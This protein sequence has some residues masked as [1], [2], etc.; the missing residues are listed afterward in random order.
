MRH[1][2]G[3]TRRRRH[4]AKD[5]AV[6]S[7]IAV[8]F[9]ILLVVAGINAYLITTLPQQMAI[10][11]EQHL[12]QVENA[13]EQLQA[14]ILAEAAHPNKHVTMTT[15]IPMQSGSEPPFGAPASSVLS[16]DPTTSAVANFSYKIGTIIQTPPNWLQGNCGSNDSNAVVSCSCT[17]SGGTKYDNYTADNTTMSLTVHG[18]GSGSCPVVYNIR[19]NNSVITI[20]V[21]GKNVGQ[22]I[23]QIEGNNDT[24]RLVYRGSSNQHRYITIAIYGQNDAYSSDWSG[25]GG[26][27]TAFAGVSVNTTFVG[28]SGLLCP[29]STLSQSD[30]VGAVNP[31]GNTRNVTQ[32]FTWW[33]T[34][35]ALDSAHNWSVGS[36]GDSYGF[37]NVSGFINCAFTVFAG[38]TYGENALSG[39]FDTLGDRYFPVETVGF[40]EGAVIAGTS[41]ESS[42]MIF[43]PELSYNRTSAGNVIRMTLIQLIPTGNLI[44]SGGGTTG[45]ET[46]LLGVS[47]FA[48]TNTPLSLEGKA[49]FLMTPFYLNVTTLYPKAWLNFLQPLDNFLTGTPYAVYSPQNGYDTYEVIIPFFAVGFD[50]T[51]VSVG[52]GF[53]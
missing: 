47:H 26:H 33:N 3:R 40:E 16:A 15:P 39:I 31:G 17:G 25:A 10:L 7:A 49:P 20:Q 5:R 48:Y 41:A 28:Y 18:G 52:V 29:A 51:V 13:F 46:H 19:G 36:K 45:I 34:N 2:V 22:A 30:T 37:Y 4:Q 6:A 12:L 44:Q 50:I 24:I 1:L 14:D 42:S 8:L 35:S 43:G 53:S 9:I 11:E 32:N 23:V 38:A 27:G 21:N